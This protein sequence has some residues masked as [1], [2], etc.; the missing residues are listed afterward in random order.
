MLLFKIRYLLDQPQMGLKNYIIIY[1]RA[2]FLKLLTL[3]NLFVNC[4]ISYLLPPT[5]LN[6]NIESYFMVCFIVHYAI[7]KLKE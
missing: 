1:N 6:L 3:I 7:E 5:H 4:F 2:Y